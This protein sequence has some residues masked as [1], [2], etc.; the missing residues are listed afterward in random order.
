MSLFG[1]D[2]RE[3]G[4]DVD[5]AGDAAVCRGCSGASLFVFSACR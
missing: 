4:G 2:R 3:T 1:V 5:D